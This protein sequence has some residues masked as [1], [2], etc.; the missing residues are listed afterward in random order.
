MILISI[1]ILIG[2]LLLERFSSLKKVSDL[3][4]SNDKIPINNKKIREVIFNNRENGISDTDTYLE[5]KNIYKGNRSIAK[6][7]LE[8]PEKSAIENYRTIN[9]ILFVSV[10]LICAIKLIS[11]YQLTEI[12]NPNIISLLLYSLIAFYIYDFNILGYNLCI[13]F[14]IINSIWLIYNIREFNISFASELAFSIVFLILAYFLKSKLFKK[15]KL[16][17]NE[18]GEYIF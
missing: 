7:I 14:S 5:L 9:Q 1:F 8:T 6:S 13:Y 12:L 2:L 10:I 18:N 15:T 16:K 17:L 11:I 4:Q 3:S